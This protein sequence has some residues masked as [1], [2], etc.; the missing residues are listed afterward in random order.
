MLLLLEYLRV[1]DLLYGIA[2][3]LSSYPYSLFLFYQQY[4]YTSQVSLHQEDTIQFIRLERVFA[5]RAMK[6]D[7][8][9]KKFEWGEG[10][11]KVESEDDDYW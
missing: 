7:P 2:L 9:D 4:P 1:S 5:V 8:G 3:S 6:E 11:G 10:S